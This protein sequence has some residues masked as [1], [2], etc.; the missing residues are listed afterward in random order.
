LVGHTAA[1]DHLELSAIHRIRR[2]VEGSDV[3]E[4]DE[5]RAITDRPEVEHL[6]TG[7][8]Y[9]VS[10][11]CLVAFTQHFQ[12][13]VVEGGFDLPS[14]SGRGVR[15]E[16]NLELLANTDPEPFV[17]IREQGG[18]LSN[19]AAACGQNKDRK[20]NEPASLHISIMGLRSAPDKGASFQSRSGRSPP[21]RPYRAAA[22]QASRRLVFAP[23]RMTPPM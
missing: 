18:F 8:P 12:D 6:M 3:P 10:V 23:P 7:G 2:I 11:G 21:V 5:S 4:A 22:R 17:P 9:Q 14:V 20:G 1:D 19:A 16:D 13:V 15:F